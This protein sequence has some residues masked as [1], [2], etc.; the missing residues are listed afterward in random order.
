MAS[1]GKYKH[2]LNLPE[3]DFPMRGNMA[4]REPEFIA[5][6]E[7][8]DVYGRILA[9]RKPGKKYILHDGPPYS[10]GNLHHGHILNN[11]L[12]DIVVKSKSMAG[13]YAPFVPGW[14]TH[15]LPIELAVDRELGDRKASM[16]RAEIRA[17]CREYA[18]K[19]VD[20]QRAERRRLG[21]FGDWDHPYLTLNHDY[22]AA[23]VRALAAFAR[24][25]YLERGKKPVHWCPQDGTALAEAEIEY[26]DHTSPSIHVRMA[27]AEGPGSSPTGDGFDPAT[28]DSRLAGRRLA[29][30]IWTTTPWTL[31][32]NLAVVLHRNFE[33]VAVPSPRDPDE[34]L[35]CAKALAPA[36]LAAA[37]VAPEAASDASDWIDIAPERLA[38]LEGQRY[39]HPFI[40]APKSDADFRIWFADYVTLEQGTG[41]VHTAPGHG[42]DDYATGIAHGLEPYAPVDGAGRFTDEVP[43]WQG[44]RTTEANPKIV[45]HLDAIG[46]LLSDPKATIGHSY[47]HCWRCKGPVLFRATPQWFARIDHNAMRQRALAE[48]EH[49]EWIPPWGEQRISGMIANRPDW[50]LSR[51]R[52]WGVPIPAVYCKACGDV[53]ADAEM[54]DHVAEV[55]AE[56]GADSWYRDPIADLLPPGFRCPS[57]GSDDLALEQDIVDVWFESGTSWLAVRAQHPELSDIDLYLEGSDQHRGW[58]HSSLLVGIGVAG[59]APYKS[60]ITHGFVLDDN[61]RPYS[62]SEIER[63]RRQGKKVKFVPPGDTIAQYGAEL[64][65]LWVASTEFRS[66]IP[67]SDKVLSGLIDWVKKFRNTARFLLGNLNDFSPDQTPLDS[68]A[69]SALDRHALARLGD[70]AYRVREAYASFELHVVYRTLV[71]Y[72]AVDLSAF[73]LDIVKDRLYSSAKDAPERRAAQAVIYTI[74]RTLAALAAPILAFSAEDVWRH[75]PRR[76]GDP[77]SVHLLVFPEGKALAADDPGALAW[78]TLL[79]Y[80]D[81]VTQNLEAFRQKKHRSLDARVT[82]YPRAADRPVLA[83]HQED[84]ADLFIVS[85]VILGE[86]ATEKA[87]HVTIDHAAGQRCERCWKWSE[88]MATDPADVCERCGVALKA[89]S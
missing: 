58:F 15:G 8:S 27:M 26:R 88:K 67:Y 28:L 57:C 63:A 34:Y 30:T 3:T 25:G 71:D 60:V 85:Q 40:D 68:C 48:I 36:L 51:Q 75:L 14:D 24:G 22:E 69:L 21:S 18:L 33:Y 29:L 84:L 86:D 45:A 74:T 81:L 6:W 43:L 2:T 62:K 77:D 65:R 17:A 73:Y 80:R 53:R 12:K 10:N 37:G 64:F 52:I 46:A 16:S 31:P 72:V 19:F 39:R 4:A 7:E 87:P 76:T 5:G 89:Q 1:A 50:C 79:E 83:Q 32:A 54:M 41:L 47:P 9:A 42:A 20:I 61:G 38:T 49:T 66:D 23:I 35:L 82:L 44:Q 11:I 55:F 59:K 78:A 70:V 56:R 13:F